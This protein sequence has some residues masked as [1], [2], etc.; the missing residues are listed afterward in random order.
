MRKR[1]AKARAA[2]QAKEGQPENGAAPAPATLPPLNY[3]KR[4]GQEVPQT[5]PPT[6]PLDVMYPKKRY[7]A[8]KQ[9][10]HPDE[11]FDLHLVHV[12]F[13]NQQNNPS[14]FRPKQCYARNS[15]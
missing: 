3:P 9:E 13:T 2:E 5:N 8:G 12:L 1:A 4:N 11:L 14:L 6:I 10:K 15:K 7:P